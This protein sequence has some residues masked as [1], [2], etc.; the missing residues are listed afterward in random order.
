MDRD[1][2]GKGTGREKTFRAEATACAKALRR[3]KS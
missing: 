2:P 1:V 3:E